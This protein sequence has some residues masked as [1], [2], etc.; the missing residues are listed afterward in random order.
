M[1]II[2]WI[3]NLFLNS[4][5]NLLEIFWRHAAL[6]RIHH[7]L[8]M[9]TFTLCSWAFQKHSKVMQMM[10]DALVNN[11]NNI[12]LYGTNYQQTCCLNLLHC[13]VGLGLDVNIFRRNTCVWNIPMF[14]VRARLSLFLFATIDHVIDGE[15]T[16]VCYL[17]SH[18]KRGQTQTLRLNRSL[19]NPQTAQMM[20]FKPEKAK[21]VRCW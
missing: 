19:S 7:P 13:Y 21:E 11:E 1:L 6:N 20:G 16:Y 3:L 2:T 18:T 12:I 15:D 14:Q 8:T 10:Y 5:Y 4:F 17:F 9:H